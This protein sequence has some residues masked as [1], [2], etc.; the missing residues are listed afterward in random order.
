MAEGVR[1]WCGVVWR[2][3]EKGERRGGGAASGKERRMG[4]IGEK[5][6]E[7]WHWGKRGGWAAPGSLPASGEL[8]LSLVEQAARE[9]PCKRRGR[10]GGWAAP[11]SSPLPVAAALARLRGARRRRLVCGRTPPGSSPVGAT[12][13]AHLRG[14]RRRRLRGALEMRIKIEM[15][16]PAGLAFLSDRHKRT[17][18]VRLSRALEMP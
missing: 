10:R 3:R 15:G 14:D 9:L 5:E 6:E 2:E 7:G 11:G 16:R 12:A 8:R 18:F 13:P 17:A 4:G 1:I